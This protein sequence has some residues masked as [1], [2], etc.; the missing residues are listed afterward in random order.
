[1]SMMP[2]DQTTVEDEPL[3]DSKTGEPIEP[4]AKATKDLRAA[5]ARSEK[6]RVENEQLKRESAFLRAG[7]DTESKAGKLLLKAYDGDLADI[8]ALKA[9]A[10]SIGALTAPPAPAPVPTPVAA[11]PNP[12]TPAEAQALAQRGQTASGA[13]PSDAV[14]QG[15]DPQAFAQAEYDRMTQAGHS[16]EDAAAQA[17]R[18]LSQAFVEG[19]Q[20]VQWRDQG[21]SDTSQ[22]YPVQ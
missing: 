15:R 21:Q 10:E 3:F 22:R 14:T 8:D 20:R 17:F 6:L 9:E 4:A 2:D 7:V 1:M 18:V 11:V 12:I 5:A 16:K 19:D 13:P